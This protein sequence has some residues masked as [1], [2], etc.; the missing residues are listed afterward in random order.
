MVDGGSNPPAGVMMRM[1]A[2]SEAELANFFAYASFPR[3]YRPLMKLKISPRGAPVSRRRWASSNCECGEKS[4]LARTP[5][6]LAGD[7]R[8]TR[9]RAADSSRGLCCG[10]AT[11]KA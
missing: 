11:G 7:K 3:K 4:C 9:G 1:V 10:P 8:K 2:V 5:E 6:A